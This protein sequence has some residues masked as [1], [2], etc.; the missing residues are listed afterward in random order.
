[1]ERGKNIKKPSGKYE[2]LRTHLRQDKRGVRVGS[3]GRD[4]KDE[5][6][7]RD[8]AQKHGLLA[9]YRRA[10][11]STG[12][13]HNVL[14]VPELQQFPSGKLRV[15]GLWEKDQKVVVCNLWRKV[16]LEATKQTVGRAKQGKVL[17]RHR[18]S[19]RIRY[20]RACAQT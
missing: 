13:S 16:R 2:S 11:W 12:R 18:Y 8:R 14:P 17:S 6:C 5:H 9:A 4:R 10:S 1:M 7:E 20:L 15:V 3:T 19:K